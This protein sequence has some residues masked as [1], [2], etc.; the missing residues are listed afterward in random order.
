MKRRKCSNGYPICQ[1][2]QVLAEDPGEFE[3]TKNNCV[4]EITDISGG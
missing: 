1:I 4:V 3:N 2:N